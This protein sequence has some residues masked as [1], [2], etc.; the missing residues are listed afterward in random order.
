MRPVLAL[1]ATALVAFTAAAS[2]AD[3][4]DLT[5]YPE[6]TLLV[7]AALPADVQPI[8]SV[9]V[10]SP[11]DG[12][13]T[14]NLPAPGARLPEGTVWG[15]FEPE[16]LKL[17]GEAVALARALFEEKESP[18][19][20]LDLARAA[21]D[22]AERRSELQRQ[23]DML[24]RIAADPA[25]ADLY[26]DETAGTASGEEVAALVTRLRSQLDLIEYVFRYVGTPRESELERRVLDLKLRAQEL[27]FERRLRDFRLA[28]PFAG[29]LTLIPAPPPDGQPLRV[30]LGADLALIR[31]FSAIEAR[32]PLRR[33][34]WRLLEPGKLILRQSRFGRPGI[35]AV[36]ER[37]LQQ[38][39]NGRE[40]LVYVFRFPDSARASARPLAGGQVMM[41][42]VLR[43]DAPARIVPKIDLL[44]ASPAAF[45]DDGWE[46]GVAAA[47]PGTRLIA[48]GET[49]AALQPQ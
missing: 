7:L 31:D 13:L 2:A 17:E 47:A 21:A 44:L 48:L 32:V 19:L 39:I 5:R 41:E 10:K 49:H 16:R 24:A 46:S 43:L 4:L 1:T 45:R 25:L 38:E 23:T 42:L 20:A 40:E 12:L 30:P 29:E 9:R 27:E 33:P 22:L 6:S 36:F 11:T 8:R 18:K 28:M 26:A 15:E 3:R 14:L 37:G 35:A 34:E